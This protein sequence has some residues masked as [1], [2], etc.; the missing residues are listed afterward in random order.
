M[1][2]KFLE[3]PIVNIADE[4][5]Y[6]IKLDM[7][8]TPDQAFKVLT[9]LKSMPK[10]IFNLKKAELVKEDGFVTDNTLQMRYNNK[11]HADFIEDLDLEVQKT[12]YPKGGL[13]GFSI[14]MENDYSIELYKVTKLSNG[15][16]RLT[17][18]YE[19][20]QNL[21]D[22][23]ADEV[24]ANKQGKLLQLKQLIENSK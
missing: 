4:F 18:G 19:D 2:T 5:T 7:N 24:L 1:K 15:I 13:R 9:D 20:T 22:Y 6:Y 21:L 16:I 23:S 12:L 3:Q 11:P 8:A 14:F 10:W 17:N